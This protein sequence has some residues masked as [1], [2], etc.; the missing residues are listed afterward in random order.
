MTF[1]CFSSVRAAKP[2]PSTRKG[3]KSF[4]FSFAGGS[5]NGSSI[6]FLIKSLTHAVLRAWA[7]MHTACRSWH[8]EVKV[9]HHDATR[10]DVT[11]CGAI[12]SRA[13]PCRAAISTQHR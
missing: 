8:A 6:S 7:R 9:V 4:S 13:L 3:I 5:V 12:Q 1:S 2:V 10:H 11:R